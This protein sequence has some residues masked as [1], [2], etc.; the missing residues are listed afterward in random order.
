MKL[1]VSFLAVVVNT[2]MRLIAMPTILNRVV[3]FVLD[4]L[5][6][7]LVSVREMTNKCQ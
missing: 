5:I 6:G 4:T 3:P 1:A 7:K 2:R